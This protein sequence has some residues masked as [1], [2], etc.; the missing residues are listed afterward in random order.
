MLMP[1]L[2]ISMFPPLIYSVLISFSAGHSNVVEVLLCAKADRH[3]QMGDLSPLQ[4]AKDFGHSDIV[5]IL[6]DNI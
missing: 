3:A 2:N 5:D 1:D 6:E 4:I